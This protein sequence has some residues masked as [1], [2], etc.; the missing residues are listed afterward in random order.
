MEKRGAGVGGRGE[1]FLH[2][3]DV[4]RRGRPAEMQA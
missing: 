3:N 1:Q 2:L 4:S